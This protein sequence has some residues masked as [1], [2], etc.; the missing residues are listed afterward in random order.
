MTQSF[1]S[2]AVI[3]LASSSQSSFGKSNMCTLLH[4]NACKRRTPLDTLML[5]ATKENKVA[6]DRIFRANAVQLL[7]QKLH[8]IFC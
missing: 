2:T 8:L 1:A 3:K 6:E 4:S 5:A 7:M